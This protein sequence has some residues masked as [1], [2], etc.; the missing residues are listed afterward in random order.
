MTYRYLF[1]EGCIDPWVLEHGNCPTCKT[2]LLP[3]EEE[4]TSAEE[5]AQEFDNEDDS[6]TDGETMFLHCKH[7]MIENFVR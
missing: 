7:Y 4:E 6:S 2:E 5:A 3:D 1:H